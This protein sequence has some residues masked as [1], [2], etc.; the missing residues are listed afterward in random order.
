MTEVL[1]SFLLE[2]WSGSLRILSSPPKKHRFTRTESLRRMWIALFLRSY[3]WG[4]NPLSECH[5]YFFR[6]QGSFLPFQIKICFLWAAAEE[7]LYTETELRWLNKSLQTLQAHSHNL[8]FTTWHLPWDQ[9]SYIIFLSF[10]SWNNN[11]KCW[12]VWSHGRSC[13]T[14]REHQNKWEDVKL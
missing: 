5:C 8:N 6:E 1:Y 14:L 7:P 9:P 12:R 11:G 3:I 10:T 4:V 13:F 2:A